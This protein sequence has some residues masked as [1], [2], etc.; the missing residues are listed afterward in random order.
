MAANGS[1]SLCVYAP[2]K[3]RG[4]RKEWLAGHGGERNARPW[5]RRK[6]WRVEYAHIAAANPAHSHYRVMETF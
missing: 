1:D 6:R 4:G 2:Q 5:H 3:E